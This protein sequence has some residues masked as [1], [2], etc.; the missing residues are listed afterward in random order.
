MKASRTFR[1][2]MWLGTRK[3]LR[4]FLRG[5]LHA[6]NGLG[7]PAA[8]VRR[9]VFGIGFEP[10]KSRFDVSNGLGNL[11]AGTLSQDMLAEQEQPRPQPPQVDGHA[12]RGSRRS[13]GRL[14]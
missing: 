12:T 5:L 8:G 6:S 2:M 7:Y 14:S 10:S 3:S 9:E 13:L 11:R 4:D 1:L